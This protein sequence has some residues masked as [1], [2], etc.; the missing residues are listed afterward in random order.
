MQVSFN[1]TK[2]ILDLVNDKNSSLIIFF[3]SLKTFKIKLKEQ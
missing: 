2:K 1:I 3:F